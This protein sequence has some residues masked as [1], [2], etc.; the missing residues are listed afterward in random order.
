MS[1]APPVPVRIEILRAAVCRR[2]N[3]GGRTW[4]SY[5]CG[6]RG[7]DLAGREMGAVFGSPSVTRKGRPSSIGLVPMIPAV[8]HGHLRNRFLPRAIGPER[9]ILP[10]L[11]V[12]DV[13]DRDGVARHG[14]WWR[15]REGGAT[16]ESVVGH[17]WLNRWK[18]RCLGPFELSS[19]I[20]RSLFSPCPLPLWWLRSLRKKSR[21]RRVA[22]T[23]R[24]T[25]SDR[26]PR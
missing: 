22:F 17:G 12:G 3:G 15:E 24:V 23:G 4:L 21:S 19:C 13:Q 20:A 11:H 5:S 10:K 14:R 25:C 2:K 1:R 8:C 7:L 26:G 6:Q 16:G 18:N 9:M